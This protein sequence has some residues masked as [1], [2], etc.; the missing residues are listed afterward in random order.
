[1]PDPGQSQP[2]KPDRDGGHDTIPAVE[3]SPADAMVLSCTEIT[4]SAKRFVASAT[5]IM[6]SVARFVT[7]IYYEQGAPA[8]YLLTLADKLPVLD[9]FSPLLQAEIKREA[10]HQLAELARDGDADMFVRFVS[11]LSDCQSRFDFVKY[12]SLENPVVRARVLEMMTTR[13]EKRDVTLTAGLGFYHYLQE[14]HDPQQRE[15]VLNELFEKLRTV[16]MLDQLPAQRGLEALGYALMGYS[17]Y[18]EDS[19]DRQLALWAAWGRVTDSHAQ[20]ALRLAISF[21]SLIE[22]IDRDFKEYSQ[23]A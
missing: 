22:A 9:S 16:T 10:I 21:N 6:D 11:N 14:C 13:G 19:M 18:S 20:M 5:E 8:L 23:A 1:M 17:K 15:Q 12:S 2:L 3:L 7:T 4:G